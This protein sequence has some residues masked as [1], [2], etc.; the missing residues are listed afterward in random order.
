[1]TKDLF[2]GIL[3]PTTPKESIKRLEMVGF[4]NIFQTEFVALI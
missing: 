2:K 3:F 1:L 4:K